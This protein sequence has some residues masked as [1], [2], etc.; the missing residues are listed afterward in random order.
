MQEF[1]QRICEKLKS[2]YLEKVAHDCLQSIIQFNQ[3]DLHEVEKTLS[4]LIQFGFYH[5]AKKIIL[6]LINKNELDVMWKY[7]GILLSKTQI[8][9]HLIEK[10]EK[11]TSQQANGFYLNYFTY[12]PQFKNYQIWQQAWHKKI[13]DDQEKKRKQLLDKV[14]TARSQSMIDEEEFAILQLSQMFPQDRQVKKELR[15][16]RERK[17]FELL[18]KIKSKV[19]Q[20][21]FSKKQDNELNHLLINHL[22]PELNI[23]SLNDDL[24]I[25]ALMLEDY[26]TAVQI[27]QYL[28]ANEKNDWLK[29]EVF[30]LAEHALEL[31][32]LSFEIE[33]KYALQADAL[34][35]CLYYRAQAYFLLDDKQN[36]LE[37][38][39]EILAHE[40][41]YRRAAQLL[42]EW[43]E[44]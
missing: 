21:T 2:E 34:Y 24:L 11:W 38:M 10:I 7:L 44:K 43:S 22:A 12:L 26:Q 15:E 19:K 20:Q 36:A 16:F 27:A 39:N 1:E 4:F 25:A 13:N 28:D 9:S 31:L 18:D 42:R 41:H 35:A 14:Q 3:A 23:D 6:W 33:A 30:L 37:I 29:M 17:A 32:Q 40:P 8:S 5:E